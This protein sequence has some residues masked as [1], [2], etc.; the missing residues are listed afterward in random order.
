[1]NSKMDWSQKKKIVIFSIWAEMTV[2]LMKYFFK[3]KTRNAFFTEVFEP[4]KYQNSIS[5]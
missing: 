5:N 3:L 4:I 1:M 2:N